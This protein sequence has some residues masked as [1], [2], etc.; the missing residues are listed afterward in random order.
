MDHRRGD[1]AAGGAGPSGDAAR[2]GGAATPARQ[3]A[4]SF[5]DEAGLREGAVLAGKYR[6]DR[7]LGAGA[8]GVVVAATHV[9]LGSTVAIKVLRP[10]Y[11][12]RPN[13]RG[14]FLREARAASRLRGEHVAR[15]YDV[16]ESDEG[17]PFMVME[18]LEGTDLEAH[19]GAEGPLPVGLAVGLVLQ[20]CEA[21]AEA[22]ALGFIHRDLKPS[23]L[24]LTRR[25]G[26]E[27]WL[28]VL[29][30]GV[31]KELSPDPTLSPD[32]ARTTRRAVVGSPFYMAP[33]QALGSAGVDARCDVWA[34]GVILF[35]ALS[36]RRPFDGNSF[37]E[38]ATA[39]SEGEP[40]W[41][42]LPPQV[43]RGLRRALER[44]LA[45]RPAARLG[46]AVALAE[47]LGPFASLAPPDPLQRVRY[48]ASQSA[49]RSDPNEPTLSEE[50]VP[51]PVLTPR[52]R[53]RPGASP[54][55][56]T[57]AAPLE[58]PRP[59]P[60]LWLA[61]GAAV[62]LLP[63]VFLSSP[64]VTPATDATPPLPAALAPEGPAGAT[65][66]KA[67]VDPVAPVPGPAR[68]TL[69]LASAVAV[70][71]APPAAVSS[72]APALWTPPPAP[73]TQ[74][75]RAPAGRAPSAAQAVAPRAPLL[76]R[77]VATY[78]VEPPRAGRAPDARG[79]EDRF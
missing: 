11:A 75:P 40:P 61:A 56:P 42:A 3:R 44:C 71:V 34:L 18:R 17:A 70:D 74:P 23:N 67:V 37:A 15:V 27:P 57:A 60:W 79:V 76:P 30:F 55:A 16:G 32:G 26:G 21:L 58:A 33:E 19:L 28:K 35:E 52:P 68:P 14:R 50:G 78:G 38:I 47:A 64:W 7:L 63:F 22:H 53:R 13:A 12:S 39:L 73:R 10:E 45:K 54:S 69:A 9:L 36:G 77:G 41:G 29:D 59:R 25:A 6:V 65:R 72:A 62:A 66:R 5:A 20:A 24:F 49:R 31:S 43:P 51:T 1:R 4:R 2:A 8:M 48:A 46:S